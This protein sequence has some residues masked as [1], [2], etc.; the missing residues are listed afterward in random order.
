MEQGAFHLLHRYITRL[1]H[2]PPFALNC[3]EKIMALDLPFSVQLT[4]R[5]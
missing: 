2:K 4:F 1:Q 5:M 3:L